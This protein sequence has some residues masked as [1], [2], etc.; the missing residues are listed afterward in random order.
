M[1]FPVPVFIFLLSCQFC[2]A[3]E[4]RVI[5]IPGKQTTSSQTQSANSGDKAATPIKKDSIG[6][7]HR[8][9]DT[10]SISYKYIDSV[11][12]N[13]MDSS[14]NDFDR[15]FSVPSSY[16]LLGNHGAAAYPLIYTPNSKPGF[17]PGF[18][19][20]D[21]YRFTLEGTKFYRTTKP[22]S[23]L[24]YQLAGGKEQMIK[25]LHTQ[26]PRPNFNFGLDYRL[27]N[28]PGFFTSQ[29]TNHNAYRLFS[30]Y[31]GK[32]KRHAASMV[33]LGNTIKNN[34]NGGIQNDAALADPNKKDRFYIDVNLG[35]LS[36]GQLNP[37][38]TKVNTGNIYKDF[39]FYLRN[40]YDLGKRDSIAINDSTTEYLFYPKLRLQHTL[41]YNNYSYNY[42]DYIGDS[43]YYKRFYDTTLK[44]ANDT[45]SVMERW[46]QISNDFSILQFPE[47]RNPA[48]FF[49]LGATIENIHGELS[50][51]VKNFYNV[52]LHAE[53]RNKTRNKLWDILAK[54]E[55]YSAGYNAGDYR[56]QATLGRYLNKK[57]GDVKLFFNNVNRTPSF[58]FNNLS[59]FNFKNNNSFKKE[60]SLSFGAQSD[61][62]L[63]S[64][65]FK[66]HFITNL[67]YFTN[68]YKT[69]QYSKVINL[70]QVY[71]SKK[72][73]ISKKW[74]WYA[75]AVLQQTDGASPIKVPLLFTRNRFAFEGVFYR[76]LNLS[77]GI[78]VRY[79]TPYKGYNYSPVMGQFVP[80]DTVRLNNLPDIAA[81]LH[82]RIKS[83]T[84]FVRAE[85]L[86]TITLKNGFG[87]TNNNF[88]APHYPTQAAVLRLGIRWGFIN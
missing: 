20:F 55:L 41:T 67:A 1:K 64:I 13:P 2:L 16:Q 61:N 58:I 7:V 22:Y 52:I 47:T 37:F 53:Y 14:I 27:I 54:G 74:N 73:R 46:K 36:Q 28:A 63:L 70:L 62:A 76:N 79:Y 11:R 18:H 78:E 65:G 19:A 6:F 26:N 39:T 51:G 33:L 34:E 50:S 49:L 71:A 86:N 29:N 4:G 8:V 24:G 25:I 57:L 17:D 38:N 80:Q 84:G 83:F 12:S 45:L 21:V 5:K 42:R 85:N 32:R 40:S 68:F 66:N 72:I 88:A 43:V 69:A 15:Y 23:Q 81:Y 77:M 10:I 3:Q 56:A 48:Q 9:D 60:N 31:Q 35:N 59:S 30:A 82:F 44:D 87:F 75:E